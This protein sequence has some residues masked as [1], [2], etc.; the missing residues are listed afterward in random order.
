[1]RAKWQDGKK[2]RLEECLPDF[3][4]NLSRVALAFKLRRRAEEE[5]A[6]GAREAELRRREEAKLRAEQEE[7]RRQEARRGECL[8]AEVSRWRRAGDIRDYVQAAIHTLGGGDLESISDAAIREH[9]RWA[10]AYAESLD[11]LGRAEEPPGP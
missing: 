9:L 5:R 3:V 10:L 2:Q 4:G 6:Q 1:M 8:E 11:P 7:R